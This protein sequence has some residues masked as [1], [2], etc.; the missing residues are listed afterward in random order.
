[1]TLTCRILNKPYD[2]L[3]TFY[4]NEYILSG[5]VEQ[6]TNVICSSNVW[7]HKA[8]PDCTSEHKPLMSRLYRFINVYART[9]LVAKCKTNEDTGSTRYDP[10]ATTTS[11]SSRS[12]NFS[13]T[14]TLDS[15]FRFVIFI[16][17]SSLLCRVSPWM[18]IFF[19]T[20]RKRI[21]A[22]NRKYAN[23]PRFMYND[24]YKIVESDSENVSD[25]GTCVCMTAR[26]FTCNM[27]S[28]KS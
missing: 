10:G 4:S 7:L 1:M 14:Q 26:Q 27:Y 15:N 16:F 19:G 21:I 24:G 20:C 3:G 2:T 8:Y 12:G 6:L 13:N 18:S 25:S 11:K 23:K 17:R 22:T 9:L 5:M 28:Y